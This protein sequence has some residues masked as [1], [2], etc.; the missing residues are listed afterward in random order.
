MPLKIKRLKKN[1]LFSEEQVK[2]AITRVNALDEKKLSIRKAA[3]IYNIPR[4]TL[5]RR[6]ENNSGLIGSGTTTTLSRATEELL[7]HSIKKVGS[8]GYGLT[9]RHVQRVVHHYLV[10]T[11]Q[12]HL[13]NNGKPGRDWYKR[14]K[15]R[16]KHTLSEREA[17]NIAKARAASCT[18]N[19]IDSYFE[20]LVK[21]YDEAELKEPTNIWN[22]DETGFSGDQGEKK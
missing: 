11:K 21:A 4:T 12:T 5:Q 14:F 7:V 16:W 8:W 2:E 20:V 15:Q 19:H 9:F 17:E 1:N 13:F 6:I 3:Q 18:K 10:Q 22:V